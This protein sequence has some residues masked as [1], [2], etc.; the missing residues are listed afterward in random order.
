MVPEGTMP[1]DTFQ[2]LCSFRLEK[3]GV[4]LTKMGDAEMEKSDAKG[5]YSD[6]VDSMVQSQPEPQQQ[7]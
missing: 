2:E 4:C 1:G 3:G 6:Y 7:T 5:D